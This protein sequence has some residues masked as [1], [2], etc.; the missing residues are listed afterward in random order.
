MLSKKPYTSE[1][2]AIKDY[3]DEVMSLLQQFNDTYHT[4]RHLRDHMLMSV[5]LHTVHQ[6]L[7]YRRMRAV[8]DL[9]ELVR[10]GL[11]NMKILAVYKV[12][13][14]SN[15]RNEHDADRD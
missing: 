4:D 7:S 1:V 12:E 6:I 8:Y 3:R 10:I 11:I 5:G 2:D 14:S 15:T 13:Y 9:I